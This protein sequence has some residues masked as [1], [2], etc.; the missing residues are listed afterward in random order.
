MKKG[1]FWP[2]MGDKDEIY[3]P[4]S[5][6]RAHSNVSDILGEYSRILLA[7]GYAAYDEFAE[8]NPFVTLAQCWSHTRRK[9]IEAENESPKL[10]TTALG[11]IGGLYR[12]DRE[13]ADKTPDEV[14]RVRL[15][16]SWKV[17][18]E[19]MEWLKATISSG[20]V[21]ASS[22]FMTAAK[23]A[24]K[25]ES[26]LRVFLRNPDV[27][28]DTNHLERENKKIAIGKKNW[29][30]CSTEVGARHLG[31]LSSLVHTA[32]LQGIDPFTYLVDV[33]QRIDE[34]KIA[35]VEQLTPRLWKDNFGNAPKI[36]T[37]LRLY[38]N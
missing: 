22:L 21:L 3:F 30:F 29:L 24:L 27:A 36:P 31:V 11:Y 12:L 38:C 4:F 17:V 28:L 6:S 7:D 35:D 13:T 33:L 9:F 8:K 34:V 23:Y 25:R 26:E 19:F 16:H 32:V 14:L 2:V 37:H 5:P 20:E 18:D 15:E 1:Y 10:V